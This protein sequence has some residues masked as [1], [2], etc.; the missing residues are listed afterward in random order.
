MIN[1][2]FN[3]WRLEMLRDR[4]EKQIKKDIMTL[5]IV[6]GAALVLV[7]LWKVMS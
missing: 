7:I 2:I 1:Q 6:L 4:L 3:P 5:K